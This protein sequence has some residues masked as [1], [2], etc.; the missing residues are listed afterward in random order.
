MDAD[1]QRSSRAS[2]IDKNI[3][4]KATATPGWLLDLGKKLSTPEKGILE[5][6]EEDDL[7][8]SLAASGDAAFSKHIWNMI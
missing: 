7:S 6:K 5:V 2:A 4:G 8:C 3:L 1:A